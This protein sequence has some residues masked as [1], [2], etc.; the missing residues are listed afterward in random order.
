MGSY[1]G[2]VGHLMQHWTICELLTVASNHV[3]GLNYIDAHAMAPWA[4]QRTRPDREFDCVRDGL[5][6]QGSA[7]QRAWHRITNLHQTE[8]YPSSAAF[9][10]ELWN[11]R[12]SLLLCEQRLETAAEIMQ[13]LVDVGPRPEPDGSRAV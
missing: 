1:M 4:T 2:N 13:W 5:P 11:R 9:V 8:G 10:H 12:Y 3:A 6:G 7:Y